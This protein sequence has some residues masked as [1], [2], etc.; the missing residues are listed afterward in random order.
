[1]VGRRSCGKFLCGLRHSPAIKKHAKREPW[2]RRKRPTATNEFVFR[3]PRPDP[4]EVEAPHCLRVPDLLP[5]PKLGK[6]QGIS[7]LESPRVIMAPP[8][9]TST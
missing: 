3:Q 1:M 8:I 5:V 6:Q 7:A 9:S 4:M 2:L